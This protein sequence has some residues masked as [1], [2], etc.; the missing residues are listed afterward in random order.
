MFA[1]KMDEW[2]ADGQA[3]RVTVPPDAEPEDARA[4]D[5]TERPPADLP[6][7]LLFGQSHF[8]DTRYAGEPGSPSWINLAHVAPPSAVR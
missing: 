1:R 5:N 4:T 3:E 2:Q 6:F 8:G 7:E